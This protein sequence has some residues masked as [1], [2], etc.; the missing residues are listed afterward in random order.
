[1]HIDDTRRGCLSLSAVLLISWLSNL[2]IFY[3]SDQ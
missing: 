1:M 2:K 3:V